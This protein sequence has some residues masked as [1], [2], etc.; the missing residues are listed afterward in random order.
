MAIKKLTYY[1]LILSAVLIVLQLHRWSKWTLPLSEIDWYPFLMDSRNSGFMW[2][3]IYGWIAVFFGWLAYLSKP[4]Y[5]AYL[6][7]GLWLLWLPNTL[8]LVTDIKYYGA[9]R[10]VAWWQDVLFF[11]AIALIGILLYLLALKLVQQRF[12]FSKRG[13]ILITILSLIGVIIGRILRW[14]SW[15]VFL[16]PDKIWESIRTMLGG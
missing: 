13:T 4:K 12:G 9:D 2:N 15:D 11:G 3:V 5:L 14:N 10:M 8:Y 6:L 1:C 7:A 16:N